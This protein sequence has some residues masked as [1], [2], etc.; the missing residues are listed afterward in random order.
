MSLQIPFFR[1]SVV[2]TAA[3]FALPI[4]MTP[5]Q[6]RADEAYL[7]GPDKIV[8]VDVAN[9][10]R[11]KHADPC[12]AAYYGLT[13]KKAEK[14]EKPNETKTAKAAT[15]TVVVR[16]AAVAPELRRLSEDHAAR[17]AVPAAKLALATRLAVAA[18][19][20]DYRNVRVLN[21]ATPDEAI[22]HHTR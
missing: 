2:S 13:V 3:L 22:F 12:I 9:L 17:P 6:V 18:P 19:D 11:M 10:E 14:A 5:L 4:A 8:Y 7:C 1:A 20:T 16:K 21:P 15:Q